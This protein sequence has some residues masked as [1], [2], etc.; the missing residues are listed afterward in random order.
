MGILCDQLVIGQGASA[1]SFLY[2]QSEREKEK[3]KGKPVWQVESTLTYAIGQDDLWAKVVSQ[4]KDHVFGQSPQIVS[5]PGAV[6]PTQDNPQFQTAKNVSTQLGEMKKDLENAGI[7]FRSGEVTKVRRAG[8]RFEVTTKKGEV[9]NPRRVIVASGFGPSQLPPKGVLP[10]DLD[11]VKYS[12]KIIGGTEYLSKPVERPAKDEFVVAVMG[13]SATSS[14]VVARAVALKATRILWISRGGFDDANPAGRNTEILE[15]AK[16]NGWLVVAGVVQVVEHDGRLR[17]TLNKAV[18]RDPGNANAPKLSTLAESY[19][20]WY[21]NNKK[22]KAAQRKEE[23][24]LKPTQI[25]GEAEVMIDHFVYALGADS[26]LPGGAKDILGPIVD[27]LDPVFDDD[28]RFG[29]VPADTTVAFKTPSGDVWVVGAAVFRMIGLDHLGA[30]KN[31]GQKF[32][33]IAKMMCESGTP[34]EGIAAIFASM[35]AVTG[36]VA[37]GKAL[38]MQTADFKEAEL[39]ISD[40]YKSKTGKEIPEK[41][42]RVMADQIVA[43]RKHTVH[44]LSVQEISVLT[45]PQNQD[46]QAFWVGMFSPGS[47][48]NKLLIDELAD[49]A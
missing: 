32:S 10:D 34:P 45:D 22:S 48:S 19:K 1:L 17:L 46:S 47:N 27:E 43:M 18:A 26:A 28:K 16:K 20:S 13:T 11:N 30:D 14:W 9:Y 23:L 40:L 37:T 36:Y 15:A 42:R 6:A 44:G 5:K 39:W 38:N 4:N 24:G 49:L 7:L 12:D 41:T 35:K 31:G 3:N 8:G 2:Y 29:D 21:D 33:N 25:Q